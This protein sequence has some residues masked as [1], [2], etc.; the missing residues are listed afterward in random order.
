MTVIERDRGKG[1]NI[2]GGKWSLG[3]GAMRDGPSERMRPG[4]N[5]RC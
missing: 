1:S 2:G 4:A 5:R 3:E